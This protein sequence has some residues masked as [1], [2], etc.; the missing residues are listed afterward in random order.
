MNI[1]IDIDG[2]L[3]D[4]HGF[5]LK[6]APQYFKRKFDRDVI[7]EDANDIREI[8]NCPDNE[9]MSYWKR[10]LPK[11]ITIEPARKGAKAFTRKLRSDGHEVFIISKRVFACRN[12]MM[13]KLMRCI[14]RNWLWRNGIWYRELIF[15]DAE[16]PDSKKTVCLEKNVEV[17]IDDEPV[18]LFSVAPV[19]KAI[20]FETSY[21]RECSGEN[22]FRAKDYDEVYEIIKQTAAR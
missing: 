14:V 1:G 12:D 7:N 17:M 18:N 13:G 3:T 6:H 5:T 10:Y 22:I 20:C 16:I 4:I 11:Y 21:N 15:C 19:A 2:V 8:F 9:W